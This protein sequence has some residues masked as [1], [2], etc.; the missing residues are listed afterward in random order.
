MSKVNVESED[1]R[2]FASHLQNVSIQLS[3]IK[4]STESRLNSLEWDDEGYR[5]FEERYHEGVRPIDHLLETL[6]EFSIYLSQKADRIDA[7]HNR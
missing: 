3:E 4:S 7:V 1:L 2:S 5:R 6:D